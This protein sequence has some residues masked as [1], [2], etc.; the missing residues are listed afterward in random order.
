MMQIR[1][2]TSTDIPQV[3]KGWNSCFIYN[4]VTEQRFR[5]IVLDDL[6]YEAEDTLVA[7]DGDEIIGFVSAVAR[8]GIS[9][10]DGRGRSGEINYGYIKGLYLLE[11]RDIRIKE[12]LLKRALDY[13]RSKGKSVVR[14]LLYTG[15][16]FFPGIDTRYETEISF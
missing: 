1:I 4:Q 11:G 15:R 5:H 12:Q 7:T 2:L 14:I 13:L 10:R 3:V 6:N 8:E 16:Y 9:G